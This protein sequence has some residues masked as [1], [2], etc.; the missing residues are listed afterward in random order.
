MPFTIGVTPET[1]RTR[2]DNKPGNVDYFKSHINAARAVANGR[3]IWITE[4]KPAGSDREI[5]DF[6]SEVM[7]WLDFSGDIHRY[8]YFMAAPAAGMLINQAQTGL[9]DIGHHYLYRN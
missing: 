5:M 4:F 3:P 6:L 8:A 7:P 9:S 2:Y 1:N